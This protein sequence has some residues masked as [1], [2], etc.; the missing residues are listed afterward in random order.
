MRDVP[1]AS[2]FGT[3]SST[4]QLPGGASR[5]ARSI[6]TFGP[7]GEPPRHPY[8]ADWSP[9]VQPLRFSLSHHHGV[10]HDRLQRPATRLLG[11]LPRRS[12]TPP[13]AH[14]SDSGR[15]YG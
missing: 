14:H 5:A 12:L 15:E 2:Q 1:R 11:S 6:V 8:P 7:I 10:E 13:H 3:T 9:F 4:G